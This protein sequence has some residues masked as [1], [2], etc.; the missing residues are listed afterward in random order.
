MSQNRATFPSK[1]S[2]KSHHADSPQLNITLLGDST[3]DNKIWVFPGLAGNVVMNKLGIKGASPHTRVRRSHGLFSPVT[4]LSVVEN[5]MDLLPNA[6]INDFTNDG[7]TT[8]DVLHGNDKDKVFPTG[9]FREFP[10]ERFEPLTAAAE[11][12]KKANYIILSVGGNNF[13]EFLQGAFGIA[14]K[15]RRLN[16]IRNQ[17]P[18]LVE[19][20]KSEYV[21][22]LQKVLA[23]NENA[24]LLLMTQYYPSFVQ[25]DYR[26]YDF[27]AAVGE[28]LHP[29]KKDLTPQDVIHDLVKQL[30]SG[31]LEAIRPYADRLVVADLTS[32]LNPNDERNHVKQIEPSGVGG[33]KIASML[34]YL[35]TK[36]VECGQVYQFDKDFFYPWNRAQ[37]AN[38][39]HASSLDQWQ[40]KH[41]NDFEQVAPQSKCSIM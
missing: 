39:V 28:A 22:L 40:P 5:L 29:D 21:E 26:I 15:Q 37:A 20:T 25:S 13:R 31:V 27:M 33:K 18:R 19:E 8:H 38:F 11:A 32:S 23:M 41:P 4:E 14:N 16:Y 1:K 6:T 2:L 34:T 17:F 3:I 35:M 24:K 7:F 36:K 12:A 9:Y 30:Y 10:N